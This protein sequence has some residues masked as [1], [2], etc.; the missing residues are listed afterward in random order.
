MN[1]AHPARLPHRLRLF[2]A[3]AGCVP[4][5]AC[6]VMHAANGQWDLMSRREPI[7]TVVADPATPARLKSQ[8]ES[9]VAIRQFSVSEL[10]LPDNDSY[11]SYA[12]VERQ[13]VVWNVFA[14]PEFSVEPRSWCFPVSGCVSYRGYFSEEKARAFAAKL[15]RRG[16]DVHVAGVPAYSTLGHFADPVLNTMMNWSDVQLAAIIFH[17]LAHQVLYVQG[18]SSFNEGFASVVED[19]G[20]R[21]W[22][23]QAGRSA[24]LETFRRQ[25]DDYLQVAR[26]F[27]QTRDRLRTLYARDLPAD[28][29]R[30]AKQAELEELR[31]AYEARKHA[32]VGRSNFD[33]WFASGINNAH[34]ASVGTYQDCVTGL[35]RLL[36]GA[37]GDLPAFYARARELGGREGEARRAQLCGRD[38]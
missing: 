4:L 13:Y 33:A 19:E 7:A 34:L 30:S 17:E 23:E 37:A 20:V 16:D 27:E 35:R 14:A 36:T 26:L 6:Y 25:R 3:L 8:L 1:R 28:E 32:G 2:V 29:K 5:A 10:G 38:A 24:D 21:R 18:D 15:A 9:V 11:R 31:R 12:D 22:L